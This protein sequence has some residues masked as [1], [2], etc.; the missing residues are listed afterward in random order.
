MNDEKVE[1]QTKKLVDHMNEYMK[2][3]ELQKK[4]TAAIFDKHRLPEGGFGSGLNNDLAEYRKKF[5]EEW[6]NDGWRN[7]QFVEKQMDEAQRPSEKEVE[8]M[9]QQHLKDEKQSVEEEPPAEREVFLKELR[10]SQRPP[11]HQQPKP[12]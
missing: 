11:S 12:R 9:H 1:K 10:N 4:G 2:A 3:S 6:G 5:A 7:K 8:Q